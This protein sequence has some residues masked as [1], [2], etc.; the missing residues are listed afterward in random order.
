VG[1]RVKIVLKELTTCGLEPGGKALELN[2]VDAAGTPV[3]LQVPFDHAQA[4]AM[5]LPRL[6]TLALKQ[7]TGNPKARYVFPLG[8]WSIESGIDQECLITTLSTEDGFEV[9]FGIP[10]EACRGLG[11]ALRDEADARA[12]SDDTQ[13]APDGGDPV[14]LN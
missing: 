7:I 9:S 3:A 14:R 4:M 6:L 2:F 13:L 12:R 10:A 8:K 1:H 11:W 5:T